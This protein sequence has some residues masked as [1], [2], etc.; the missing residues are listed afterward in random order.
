[1]IGSTLK[2]IIFEN[3]P[4]LA[5]TS[6]ETKQDRKTPSKRRKIIQNWE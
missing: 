5:T 3:F 4:N 2:C 6:P 1:M